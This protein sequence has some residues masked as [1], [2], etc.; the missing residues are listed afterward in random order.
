MRHNSYDYYF[1]HCLIVLS[2]LKTQLDL[3][4]LLGAMQESFVLKWSR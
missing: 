3:L 2:F 1:E 4:P